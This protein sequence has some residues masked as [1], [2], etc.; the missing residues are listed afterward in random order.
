VSLIVHL[1]TQ[2]NQPYGSERRCCEE[3]GT[4]I[5][6]A[7]TALCAEGLFVLAGR[8]SRTYWTDDPGIFRQL[9]S[10]LRRCSEVAGV[11][12]GVQDGD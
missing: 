6:G 2:R 5:W 1:K 8:C 11:N 3:C 12:G 10:G 4:M 7:A 9:S